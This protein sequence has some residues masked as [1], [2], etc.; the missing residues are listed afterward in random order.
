MKGLEV[1]IEQLRRGLTDA[2]ERSEL[3]QF[4]SFFNYYRFQICIICFQDDLL[5]F[6][7]LIRRCGSGY[8]SF[9]IIVAHNTLHYRR[10]LFLWHWQHIPHDYHKLFI[11]FLSVCRIPTQL[12][13]DDGAFF[14]S[15]SNPISIRLFLLLDIY[16]HFAIRT[17]LHYKRTH[18]NTPSITTLKPNHHPKP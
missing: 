8:H 9:R 1:V 16:L 13:K 2:Q 18:C 6:P 5:R 10:K 11:S 17:C 3:L 7:H 15:T 14:R 12:L 4:M